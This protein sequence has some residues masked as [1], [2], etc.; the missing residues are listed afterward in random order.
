MLEF[1]VF[2]G[3]SCFTVKTKGLGAIFSRRIVFLDAGIYRPQEFL[4]S[5]SATILLSQG[6][7]AGDARI[8]CT[9]RFRLFHNE[10]LK[11]GRDFLE[12]YRV[13]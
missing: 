13:S 6:G 11:L 1:C 5:Y 2:Y 9:S 12:N 10:N 3:F 8:L 4:V 7:V